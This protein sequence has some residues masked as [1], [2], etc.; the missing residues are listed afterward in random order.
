MTGSVA[1]DVV[2]GLIFIYLLYSLLATIVQEMISSWLE[3]RAKD[4]RQAI[5]R[6]LDDDATKSGFSK[7][8]YRSPLIKYLAKD[9]AEPAYLTPANFS[10]VVLDIL[11][12]KD[13]KPGEDFRKK[14]DESLSVGFYP[15]PEQDKSIIINTGGT[16]KFLQSLWADSQG[17]IEKFKISLEQWFND[18]MDRTSGWYK[19]KIQ[20]VL[21]CIGL[22][23]AVIFNVDTIEIAG[24]LANDP[25]LRQQ[26][27]QQADNYL[28]AH[29]HLDADIK[30]AKA[31]Q[32]SL[33]DQLRAADREYL[34]GLETT[35][36]QL[37][38]LTR[39]AKELIQKDIKSA[40]G[41]MGMGIHSFEWKGFGALCKSI[42]GWIL[43]ALAICLGAPFWFDMLNK[44]MKLRS[45]VAVSSEKNDGKP[46]QTTTRSMTAK[47]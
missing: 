7:A 44:L 18:T 40:N 41:L 16:Y 36:K 23:I 45:S 47:G 46:G 10:K 20:K 43:T 8:F 42:A 30:N 1:L 19:R 15:D 33:K 3:F 27:I 25:E 5:R 21:F 24:K 38:S 39:Q 11:R 9:N 34:Q 14:I 29:P 4:L 35:K 26:M 17:D 28:K 12:G 2:I 37:D 22:F 6:M 31:K 13:P 32:D